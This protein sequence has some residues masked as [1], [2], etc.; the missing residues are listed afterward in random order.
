[1]YNLFAVFLFQVQAHLQLEF[2]GLRMVRTDDADFCENPPSC[3]TILFPL[4]LPAPKPATQNR[5]ADLAATGSQTIPPEHRMIVDQLQWRSL[6]AQQTTPPPS[7][8]TLQMLHDHL[9]EGTSVK[10]WE[11]DGIHPS[12]WT[13]PG[14]MNAAPVF[15]PRLEQPPPPVPRPSTYAA[16]VR[17]PAVRAPQA[18]VTQDRPTQGNKQEK[19]QG[20]KQGNKGNKKKTT[21]K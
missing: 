20:K 5:A 2:P 13:G 11:T 19:E 14:P 12:P 16:A 9:R 8:P 10:P 4:A 7:G 6:E 17:Y 1:M 15:P 21:R 3:I 18:A